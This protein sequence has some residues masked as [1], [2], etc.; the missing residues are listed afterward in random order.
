MADACS[1]CRYFAAHIVT[2]T[3]VGQ[4]RRSAPPALAMQVEDGRR[5]L[6]IHAY[7]PLVDGTDWCGAFKLASEPDPELQIE[8]LSTEP[9]E[10]ELVNL[11]PGALRLCR[12]CTAQIIF[13]PTKETRMP[14][15][16]PHDPSGNVVYDPLQP[17][18]PVVVYRNG[19]AVPEDTPSDHRWHAH[20]MK[21]PGA[22][23]RK[24]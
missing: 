10:L 7:W 17:S 5:Q 18:E 12:F 13:G 21:C 23:R 16:W 8:A 15:S 2:T 11:P 14:L 6:K 19:E 1:D 9:G 4:C 22:K 3:L 20:A 24:R